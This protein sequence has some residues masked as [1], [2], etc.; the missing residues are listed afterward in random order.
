MELKEAIIHVIR[1]SLT[2]E[3]IVLK[4]ERMVDSS[5]GKVKEETDSDKSYIRHRYIIPGGP[6]A[7]KWKVPEDPQI[8]KKSWGILVQ[9]KTIEW[10]TVKEDSNKVIS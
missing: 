6:T 10:I 5:V 4:I 1:T 9:D 7:G 2:T 3:E 8:P